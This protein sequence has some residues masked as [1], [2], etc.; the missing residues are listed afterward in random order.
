MEPNFNIDTPTLLLDEA[1][2]RRNIESM[3]EKARR[4]GLHF[5]PH[6]K[7]HQSQEIGRWF[8]EY[9]IEAITVSSLKMAAYFAD[10]GWR[11]ITVAFPVNIRERERLSAL[12]S[13]VKLN[14][15]AESLESLQ[16][17]DRLLQSPVRIFIKTDTGYHR[18]GLGPGQESIIDRMLDFMD[19]SR[20]LEFAG[21]LAH[22]GH[23]YQARSREEIERVHLESLHVMQQLRRRYEGR[24]PAL[25]ISLGDTPCSSTMDDW[26]GVDEI[27]PGNF[28]FYDVTQTQIGS[29][30]ADE[31]A[32]ALACPV[33]ALHPERSEIVLYGGGVHLSKD[34]S[35][36]PDGRAFFGYVVEWEEKGWHLPEDPAFL[37][38][39]SQEHGLVVA[40]PELMK[41]VKVGEL[42]GVLPVHSCMTADL[43]KE[44]L[45]LD[46]KHIEMMKW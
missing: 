26:E 23:S 11:D 32:V 37:R 38:S 45:T 13:R 6:F 30:T 15:V 16:A 14:L 3:A 28:V 5:R 31:V 29:C 2:C 33:V 8:R 10:D 35:H 27:R 36:L 46:G 17:L 42:L 39:V 34:Y 24:Y 41:R 22:A 40:T 4:H 19:T 1:Q 9:G 18:T 21:F 7:T 25:V 20:R 44:Y 43:M 12:A